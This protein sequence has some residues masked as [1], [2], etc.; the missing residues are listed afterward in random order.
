MS[1]TIQG[2]QMCKYMYLIWIE[3][4][5]MRRLRHTNPF[6]CLISSEEGVG[7]GGGGALILIVN[8]LEINI[9]NLG[10]QHMTLTLPSWRTTNGAG[11][12]RSIHGHTE[13]N[14]GA[15]KHVR[16]FLPQHSRASHWEDWEGGRLVM[17]IESSFKRSFSAT[18]MNRRQEVRWGGL[19]V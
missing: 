17:S 18:S 7:W 6:I 4:T 12:R 9:L 13:T 1:T 19:D 16:C 10:N 5:W 15:G 11:C 2:L 3:A 8:I 14:R